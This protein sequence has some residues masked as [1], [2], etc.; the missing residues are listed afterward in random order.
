MRTAKRSVKFGNG[1]DPR[2]K[3]AKSVKGGKTFDEK[4]IRNTKLST[5]DYIE[6]ERSQSKKKGK[7][8]V[9]V[10]KPF[11]FDIRDKTRSKSIRE[12]K[13]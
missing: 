11:N 13:V 8:G 1:E 6:H 2:R 7:Y 3:R 5:K 12:R 4:S 9:T 10:P